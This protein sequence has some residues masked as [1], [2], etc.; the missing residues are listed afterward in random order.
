[1]EMK[2]VRSAQEKPGGLS[3]EVDQ[4]RGGKPHPNAPAADAVRMTKALARNNGDKEMLGESG[5]AEA[6]ISSLF[7]QAMGALSGQVKPGVVAGDVA[8]ATPQGV[9]SSAGVSQVEAFERCGELVERIVASAPSADG[10]AEVRLKIDK[11]WL[12][13]T[14]VRLTLTP[15][16]RLE[17][18]FNS[19]SLEA[20]RF[21]TPNL[22]SLRERLT[23]VTGNAVSIR[24][25]ESSQ[26]GGSRDGRS[27]NRRNVIEEMDGNS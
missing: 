21:L 17:V 8:A 25:T 2:S 9:G 23:D 5:Q 12:P 20:Q 22:G 13:D 4:A 16:S 3:G 14:E 24:M 18:E 7:S 15:D 26:D 1:M 6:G 11:P 19:A 10:S 27:R